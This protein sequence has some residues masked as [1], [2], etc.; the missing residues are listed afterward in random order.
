M[1]GVER[2]NVIY[3]PRYVR[4]M[5]VALVGNRNASEAVPLVCGGRDDAMLVE[6]RAGWSLSGCKGSSWLIPNGVEQQQ[7][8]LHG[9][10][11]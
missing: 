8:T 4:G 10:Q 9:G 6:N 7:L 2:P 5:V 1:N 11:E 3:G